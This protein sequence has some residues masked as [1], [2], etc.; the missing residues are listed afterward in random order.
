MW[1]AHA[2]EQNLRSSQ[3]RGGITDGMERRRAIPL[4]SLLVLKRWL[5][6]AGLFGRSGQQ[7][8]EM[9][10]ANVLEVRCRLLGSVQ[11]GG[12]DGQRD[13]RSRVRTT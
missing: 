8:L 2:A 7:L 11:P 9:A 1:A 12:R 13:S 6:H 5:P 4:E 10:T 3:G